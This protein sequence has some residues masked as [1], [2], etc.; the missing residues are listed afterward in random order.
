MFKKFTNSCVF[1]MNKYLPDAFIFAIVLTIITFV[2]GVALTGQTPFQMLLHWA[3]PKGFFGLL[4]F[5]MQMILVLVLGSAMAQA[6]VFKNLLKKIAKTAKTPVRGIMITAFISV[7]ACWINWGFGLVIGALLAKE[8]AREVKGI[9][10]RLLIATAYSGFIV[11]HG[12]ISGSIPLQVANQGALATVAPEIFDKSFTIATSNTIFS[13]MNLFISGII[14]FGLPFVCRAMMPDKEH[15]VEVDPAKL[16]EKERANEDPSNFTPADKMERSKILWLITLA[17]GFSYIIYNFTKVGI[18]LSLDFVN[19]I[20]MFVG[21]LLHGNLRNY[22]DAITD[23]ASSAAGIILQFPFYAG[24]MGMMTGGNV[25]GVSL[26]A[27]ISNAFVSIST[28]KTFP[29]FT[30][31][32]AGIVNFFVPSGGGQWA[33]QAPIMM[34]AGNILGVA[35]AKTAMAIAWGDAW[36][37]MIQPFWA[38]PALS[39]AGLSARDIMGYCVITL[40]FSGLVISAGFLIF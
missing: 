34:P 15:T 31:W 2:G 33:V 6:K 16:I 8:I 29:L 12:G 37:N 4:P 32:S 17:L 26:A 24:I 28:I 9:D 7:I 14:I 25:D 36:T 19:F 39:I 5:T 3:G 13:P 30:F 23:A 27:V 11:W 18:N 40:L 20:F 38:L 1:I 10:Y 22:I 21:I 35:P